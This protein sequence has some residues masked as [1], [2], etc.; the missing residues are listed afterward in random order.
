[1]FFLAKSVFV[2][3]IT[4]VFGKLLPFAVFPETYSTFLHDVITKPLENFA[5]TEY[6]VLD[7][8]LPDSIPDYGGDMSEFASHYSL[9]E[10][11]LPDLN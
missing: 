9:V 2:C 1:M 4:S 7:P 3:S 11:L 10:E 8:F 6:A 5:K